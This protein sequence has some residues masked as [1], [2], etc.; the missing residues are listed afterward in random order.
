MSEKLINKKLLEDYY[1]IFSNLESLKDFSSYYRALVQFVKKYPMEFTNE[2]K[3][4]WGLS[5]LINIDIDEYLVDNPEICLDMEKKRLVRDYESM[6][7]L[8]MT[9]SETLW[10]MVTVYSGKDCPITPNDE[11]RYI[12][13]VYEDNSDKI[14]L[15]CAGCGWTEDTNGNEYT[16]PIGKVF[17][18]N[19]KEIKSY[20][21]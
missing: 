16:G 12:K 17:P 15:E 1:D 7:T 8:S 20:I 11:L 14:L 4:V 3:D 21:K 2:I 10:D 13:I 6:D 18:A 19:E 9:I 5:E